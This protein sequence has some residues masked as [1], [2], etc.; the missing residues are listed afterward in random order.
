MLL[1]KEVIP[2]TRLRWR[3]EPTVIWRK[4]SLPSG[5]AVRMGFASCSGFGVGIAREPDLTPV[6]CRQMNVDHLDGGELVEHAARSQPW[7]QTL[8]PMPPS[9]AH[10]QILPARHR[11]SGI[12][13]EMR[14]RAALAS[15]SGQE[16][17]RSDARKAGS[18]LAQACLSQRDVVADPTNSRSPRRR[19]ADRPLRPES[20]C[21]HQS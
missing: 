12:N 20:C 18:C 16:T 9:G 14:L 21:A 7:R 10:P 8:E 2:N 19:C 15:C 4:M 3:I 1:L 6:R 13:R 11:S 17:G 5:A